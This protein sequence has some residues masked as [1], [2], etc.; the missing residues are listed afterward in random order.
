MKTLS[1]CRT[2]IF[3]GAAALWTALLFC[4][5]GEIRPV[6]AAIPPQDYRAITCQQLQESAGLKNG[7]KV[8]VAAYFW[9]FLEYEPDMVR[10]YLTLVRHP[11]AWYRLQWFAVYGSPEMKG[12]FDRLVM[13]PEQQKEYKLKR[14]EHIMI[15]GE[16]SELGA[17]LLYLQV[18]RIERI[19]TD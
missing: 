19:R 17:G 5:C 9:Q 6:P 14:L 3:W 12:Y 8:K 2:G 1:K 15:Y 7:E 11:L 4:G 16:M 13:E 18:H 10:N